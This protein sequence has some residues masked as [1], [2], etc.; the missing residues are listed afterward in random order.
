MP[1]DLV[2]QAANL[3]ALSISQLRTISEDFRHPQEVQEAAR[4]LIE[5]ISDVKLQAAVVAFDA[6]TRVF[7]GL[8]QEFVELTTLARK[9]PGGDAVATV[10]PIVRQLGD[11]FSA[12]LELPT[13]PHV[14]AGSS[15]GEP[16]DPGTPAIPTGSPPAVGTVSTSRKLS[17]IAGEYLAMFEA[18]NIDAEKLPIVVK[19]AQTLNSFRSTYEKLQES[20]GIPWYFVGLIHCMESNFNFGTHLHNGDSLMHRTVRVPKG[21]PFPDIADPPFAWVTSA[22]DALT[23]LGFQTQVDWSLP[24]QLF[25]LEQYNGF[26]YRMRGRATPYVWSFSD[27]YTQG[28]FIADGVFDPNAISK[29]CGAAIVLKQMIAGGL[30]ERP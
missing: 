23:M 25:R 21:R 1:I 16:G 10:T 19:L 26:G 11:M 6:N 30:V 13:E 29:Q 24:A 14:A 3:N 5:K 4:R 20:L 15:A 8:T 27:R 18:A 22:T 2:T 12:L 28:K 17:E 9:S 7:T